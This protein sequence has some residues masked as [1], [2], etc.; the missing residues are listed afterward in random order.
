M[1]QKVKNWKYK[2]L[3]KMY[4]RFQREEEFKPKN[5]IYRKIFLN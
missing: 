3:N 4:Y 2:L 5:E 1:Y